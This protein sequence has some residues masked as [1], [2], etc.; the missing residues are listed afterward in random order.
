MRQFLLLCALIISAVS[1]TGGQ[2]SDPVRTKEDAAVRRLALLTDLQALDAKAVKL[3]K[4]LARAAARAEIADAAWELEPEWAK[5]L[6]TEAYRLTFPEE[7][8]AAKLR[9]RLNRNMLISR[10]KLSTTAIKRLPVH[11]FAK[12]WTPTRLKQSRMRLLP[13]WRSETEPLPMPSSSCLL[14]GCAPPL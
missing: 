6:L 5:I 1:F 7:K 3:D 13:N 10:F 11:T 8:A 4:P 12:S 14:S 2:T 9:A